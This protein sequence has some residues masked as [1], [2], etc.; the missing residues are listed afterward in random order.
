MP[1]R[2]W[3]ALQDYWLWVET[4]LTYVCLLWPKDFIILSCGQLLSNPSE[5]VTQVALWLPATLMPW[6]GSCQLSEHNCVFWETEQEMTGSWHGLF[7]HHKCVSSLK[8]VTRGTE[9]DSSELAMPIGQSPWGEQSRAYVLHL[10]G[11]DAHFRLISLLSQDPEI[12]WQI[13]R[14]HQ[15]RVKK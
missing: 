10:E 13:S 12:K 5:P 3:T 6:A 15:L 9:G 1:M 7:A 8:M 4:V 14:S 11:A 2:I